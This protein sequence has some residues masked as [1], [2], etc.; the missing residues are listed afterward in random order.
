MTTCPAKLKCMYRQN[1]QQRIDLPYGPDVSG[2]VFYQA[3]SILMK[4]VYGY[5]FIFEWA[6]VRNYFH[7]AFA[8]Y[9]T[10]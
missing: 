1:R 5:Y 8:L 10:Y 3:L 6:I 9:T 7:L 4:I 2:R